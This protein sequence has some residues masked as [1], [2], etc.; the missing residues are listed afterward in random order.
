MSAK[1][2]KVETSSEIPADVTAFAQKSVDQAQAAFEKATELAHSNVQVL[3]AAS[4]ACKSRFADLQMKSMEFVQSNFNATFAFARKMLAVKDAAELFAL[5]QGYAREQV[6][7]LQ[8]QAAELNELTVLLAKETLKPVQE[9]FSRSFG[10][11]TKAFA[12]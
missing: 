5:Q 9:G 7:A 11:F 10:D 4:S 2:A 3:D 12:A 1:K 6:Q 8:R